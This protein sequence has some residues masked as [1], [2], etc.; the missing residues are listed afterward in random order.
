MKLRE[1]N[2]LLNFCR[3][4]QTRSLDLCRLAALP[5]E[6][7]HAMLLFVVR[8]RGPVVKGLV[9]PLLDWS[10]LR[11]MGYLYETT[12]KSGYTFLHTCEHVVK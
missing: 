9:T 10:W 2:K 6:T 12:G 3:N 8:Y 4:K 7:R 1:F 5:D 11:S